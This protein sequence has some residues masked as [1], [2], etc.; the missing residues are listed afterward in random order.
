[1]GILDG[2]MGELGGVAEKYAKRQIRDGAKFVCLA[3]LS[4]Y[5][6]DTPQAMQKLV[7]AATNWCLKHGTPTAAKVKA[8][9]GME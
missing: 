8:A 5:K 3:V 6:V 9:L 2:L 1:M 7:R 4:G